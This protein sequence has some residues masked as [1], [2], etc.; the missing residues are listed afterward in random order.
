MPEHRLRITQAPEFEI[1]HRDLVIDVDADEEL[2]GH[3][4]V[5]K[6]GIGWFPRGAEYERHFTWEQF[7]RLVREERG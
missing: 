3:L 2:L 1:L 4:T 5:S 7:D 6:G